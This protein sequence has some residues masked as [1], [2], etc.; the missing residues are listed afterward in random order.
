MTV[1]ALAEELRKCYVTYLYQYEYFLSMFA[2]DPFQ[3]ANTKTFP[4]EFN[5]N[6]FKKSFEELQQRN[7]DVA[8]H[9]SSSSSPY[10]DHFSSPASHSS[11]RS[12][13]PQFGDSA[14]ACSIQSH[15]DKEKNKNER[16]QKFSH[17]L[18]PLIEIN[19]H[20]C[21]HPVSAQHTIC[22]IC[23]KLFDWNC[24][25][26]PLVQ[27]PIMP[28]L[29]AR[30]FESTHFGYGVGKDYSF[31]SY[32]LHAMKF[33]HDWC[34]SNHPK[35]SNSDCM[36]ELHTIEELTPQCHSATDMPTCI[37]DI[38]EHI[39]LSGYWQIVCGDDRTQRIT[40]DYGNDIDKSSYGSIFPTIGPYARSSWN[41]HNFPLQQR[42]L[43]H[44]MK[45]ISGKNRNVRTYCLCNR[46]IW[47][48]CIVYVIMCLGVT[49]S[50]VY[51]GMMF[52]SFAWHTEDHYTYSIN[53][54]HFGAPKQW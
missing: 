49:A 37:C 21:C 40:V 14:T 5:M 19:C 17:I 2:L 7:H 20:V 25:Q 3:A 39:L 29:C 33:R 11:A 4:T 22:Y 23:R 41:L 52:T 31:A 42:S 32:A 15:K 10:R 9:S 12:S 50:W 24:V 13:T 47:S 30:C 27:T 1:H 16:I 54:N 18:N 6:S 36:Y 28:W 45:G 26:P 35:F 38:P 44:D 53:Y 8:I 46:I 34:R 43:F 48:L 51:V